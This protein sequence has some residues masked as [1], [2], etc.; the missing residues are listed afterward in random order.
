ML[1]FH[2]LCE[3]Y[4]CSHSSF[5]ITSYHLTSTVKQLILNFDFSVLMDRR[6]IGTND[7]SH[8]S[9]MISLDSFFC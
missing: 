9:A 3:L 8:S 4:C 7:L 2:F 5:G 1:L 6:S